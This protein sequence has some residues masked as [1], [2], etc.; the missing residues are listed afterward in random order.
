VGRECVRREIRLTAGGTPAPLETVATHL[1]R[2]SIPDTPVRADA[3]LLPAAPF[4]LVQ[5]SE[6]PITGAAVWNVHPCEVRNAVEEIVRAE[7]GAGDGLRWLEAWF[8]LSDS[9]VDLTI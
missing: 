2:A 6:H 9:V 7:A 5:A 1:L 3:L 4:P 8:M